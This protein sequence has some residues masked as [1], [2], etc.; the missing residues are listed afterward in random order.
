MRR[1]TYNKAKPVDKNRTHTIEVGARGAK[2]KVVKSKQPSAPQPAL[3][4]DES[5]RLLE[6]QTPQRPAGPSAHS[7]RLPVGT[8][9]YTPAV[10]LHFINEEDGVTKLAQP[11]Y[12]P[13]VC[14]IGVGVGVGSGADLGEHSVIK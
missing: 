6:P 8:P 2:A 7:V 1:A 10:P 9:M 3:S 12:P 4:R 14:C 11:D 13:K 5:L